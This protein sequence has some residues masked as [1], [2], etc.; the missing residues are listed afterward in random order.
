MT[1][2]RREEEETEECHC[3]PKILY[4]TLKCRE[5]KGKREIKQ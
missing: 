2:E 1:K 5:K 4:N 3:L